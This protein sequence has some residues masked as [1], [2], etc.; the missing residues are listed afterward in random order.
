MTSGKCRRGGDASL[1]RAR[2]GF[3]AVVLLTL[4]LGIGAPTAV[5]SVVHAVML[6]PLAYADTERLVQFR[7]EVRHP[8]GD[9]AFDALPASAA[10]EWARGSDSPTG[11]VPEAPPISAAVLALV[12]L[13]LPAPQWQQRMFPRDARRATAIAAV[14]ALRHE[15]CPAS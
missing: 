14:D 13:V 12:A 15:Q 5:S 11:V 10:L 8:Q 3:A 9:A 6:R 4:G 1:L 2:P 7:M